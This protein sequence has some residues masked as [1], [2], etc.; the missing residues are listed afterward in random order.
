MRPFHETNTFFFT[1]C[2]DGEKAEAADL[3]QKLTAE[4]MGRKD[5]ILSMW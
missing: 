1:F 2:I 5:I 4:Q 3:G